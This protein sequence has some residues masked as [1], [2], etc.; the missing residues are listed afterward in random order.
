MAREKSKKSRAKANLRNLP[1]KSVGGK[2]AGSVKGGK[3]L[4]KLMQAALKGKVFTKV[5][6]HGT[7]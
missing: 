4:P 6:I 1:A 3:A 2:Q 5:E 7:T